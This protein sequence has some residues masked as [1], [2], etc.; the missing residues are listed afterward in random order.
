M[1]PG[2]HDGGID[3]FAN[4]ES[5]VLHASRSPRRRDPPGQVSQ[6]E[7]HTNILISAFLPAAPSLLVKDIFIHSFTQSFNQAQAS[8]SSLTINIDMRASI[9]L[10]A[11]FSALAFAAPL[12][13]LHLPSD[14]PSIPSIPEEG[15]PTGG[16]EPK[17]NSQ[18]A[19]EGGQVANGKSSGLISCAS[20]SGTSGPDGSSS[21]AASSG[22]LSLSPTI[23]LG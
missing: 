6:T 17:D 21:S 19:V 9:Y 2:A 18:P 4:V 1:R 13:L 10:A 15:K 3:Q 16:K 14:S 22:G 20:S 7:R 5:A 8:A 23:N 11:V 12:P